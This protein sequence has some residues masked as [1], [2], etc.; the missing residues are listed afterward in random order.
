VICEKAAQTRERSRK[1]HW[2]S[3]PIE[4]L[5]SIGADGMLII[6]TRAS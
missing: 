3:T 6:E 5:A 2:E 1:D 4:P